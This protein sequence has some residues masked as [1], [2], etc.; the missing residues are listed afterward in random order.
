MSFSYYRA[1][2]IDHTKVPN[3]DQSNFPVLVSVTD[4][5]LKSVANSG[6]VQSGNG[7][8]IYA[9]SDAALTTRLA[10][11]RGSYN[12]STGALVLWVKVPTVATAADTT[13][14]LAYGDSGIATDPNSDGTYG[15][16]QVWDSN[17]KGV[18]HL[19]ESPSGSAPQFSDS[20]S[21]G[22]HLTIT[23]T[24]GSPATV[25]GQVG[26]GVNLPSSSQYSG[27]SAASSGNVGV[28][29]AS[30]WTVEGWVQINSFL[31]V[32]AYPQLLFGT[33]GVLGAAIDTSNKLCFAIENG[34]T[35]GRRKTASAT[36]ST[37]VWYH[38]VG[39]SNGTTFAFYLDGALIGTGTYGAT[40]NAKAQLGGSASYP[41]GFRFSN[42]RYD[43]MRLSAT[44]RS[45]DW[46]VA[47]YNNQSSPGTFATL[48]AEA[49]TFSAAWARG[50]NRLTGG[51]YV[52]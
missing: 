30:V 43:E 29:N 25:T 42:A 38:C 26:D 24:S 10:A 3:T 23:T 36:T 20:T 7:Y 37:G 22:N 31:T 46:I 8:D 19:P 14:Y 35:F 39:V 41:F 40:A 32:D 12:A 4:A 52:S 1:L 49:A 33:Q 27:S 34:G 16:A 45:A 28:G 21:N 2:V 48:G 13:I 11:E 5:A 51:L 44:N 17:F 9:Y 6:H 47:S 15:K 18:Y 50:C